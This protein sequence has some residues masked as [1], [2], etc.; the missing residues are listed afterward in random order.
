MEKQWRRIKM[1]KNSSLTCKSCLYRRKN[2]KTSIARK[3]KSELAYKG[4]SVNCTNQ[5]IN[6]QK[7]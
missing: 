4:N 1:S 2:K 7:Q 6:K 5:N 3:E